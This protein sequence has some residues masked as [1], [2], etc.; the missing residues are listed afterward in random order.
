MKKRVS[1]LIILLILVLL[2]FMPI[3]SNANEET[4]ESRKNINL[5]ENEL[6]LEEGIK[7][8]FENSEEV[9]QYGDFE[10][11]IVIDYEKSD[12]PQC[13]VI[14]K[15]IGTKS[16]V[17][18]PE[19]IEGIPVKTIGTYAFKLC[20][21]LISVNLPNTIEIIGHYA[22][23]QCRNLTNINIS[24]YVRIIGVGAFS[25]CKSLTSINLP[26]TIEV[27]ERYAFYYCH[28]LTNINFPNSVRRIG[29]EAFSYCRSLSEVILPKGAIIGAMAFNRAYVKVIY[30]YR[31]TGA[32][33]YAERYEIEFRYLDEQISDS[34]TSAT[35]SF[36]YDRGFIYSDNYFRKSAT[37]YN[38][39]LATMSLCLAF[40]AYNSEYGRFKDEN[41]EE[42]LKK[43]KFDDERYQSWHYE[44]NKEVDNIACAMS[45]KEIDGET[46]IVIAIRGGGYNNEWGSNFTVGETGDHKGFTD[47]ANKVYNRLDEYILNNNIKGKIKIW[48]TGFSRAAAT[49]NLLAAKLD[50][51]CINS[52]VSYDKNDIYAYC[53]ATPAGADTL[54][55]NPHSKTYNN[56]FNI[57]DYNDPVPLVAPKYWN[58]DRYGITYIF[59]FQE[60]KSKATIY[61]KNMIKRL[62]KLN[63]PGEEEYEYKLKE[64]K[65]R[66]DFANKDSLGTYLRKVVKSLNML[67]FSSRKGYINGT[68]EYRLRDM[69]AKF[70][71]EFNA[72][73]IFEYLKSLLY[74]DQGYLWI[75]MH[76]NLFETFHMNIDLLA[77]VH[78]EQEYYLA[79][80]QSMDSYY[81]SGAKTYMSTGTER[82]VKINCPVD[83]YVYDSSNNLVGSIVDEIPQENDEEYSI[84][85]SIDENDQ[86]V[87]YLPADEEYKIKTVAR[88]DC[89]TTI[90]IEE[91]TGVS[92]TVERIINYEEI[93]MEKDEEIITVANKYE[94]DGF[95]E[96][97]DNIEDS[98]EEPEEPIKNTGEYILQKSGEEVTPDLEISG[99]EI[100]NYSY[101]VMV[102]CDEEKGKVEG[103]GIFNI[104]EYC[105][106]VANSNESYSFDG[107]YVNNEKI[108]SDEIYRFAVKNDVKVQARFNKIQQNNSSFKSSLTSTKET[109]NLGEEFEVSF[110]ISNFEN[111]EK[112]LIA[113]GGQIEY[114]ENLLEIVDINETDSNWNKHTINDENFKFV[115]DSEEFITEDGIVFKI[116]FR[117]K[118]SVSELAQTSIF[119]KNVVAS[120]GI[121]DI[122]SNDAE[123]NINI[124]NTSGFNT[125]LSSNKENVNPKEEFEVSFG[126][127]NLLN[128][129]NGLIALGG[130]L[131]FNK[132]L[133]EI[134]DITETDSKWNKSTINNESFKFVTDSEEFVTEEGIIFKIKFRVKDDV[135]EP[136]QTSIHIKNIEASNGKE[137]ILS[138]DIETCINI[139]ISEEAFI[140]SNEYIIEDD[141]ISRIG[142]KTTLRDFLLNIE[143]NQNIK[144]IDKNGNVL[145]ENDI[146]GTGMT[147]QVGNQ[148]EYQLIVVGDIDGNGE[149]T[150]TDLAKLKLHCIAKEFIVENNEIKAADMDENNEITI[151]DIAQMKLIL[152]GWKEN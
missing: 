104:G 136:T 121:E 63:E 151:T 82:V 36:L 90:T 17:T 108:S 115:T 58:F 2:A 130:Q 56:I 21:S 114:D 76:P 132:E 34:F 148:K 30:G 101:T 28:S 18:I 71:K 27:I 13:I 55:Q 69:W 38:Q 41:V 117:V 51:T 91:C 109:V 50:R 15:Y 120:N 57:I 49:A 29:I 150:I 126:I 83:V 146:I 23:G 95:I 73:N 35:K 103:G 33:S 118:E 94:N 74:V 26:N 19:R 122:P 9:K 106:L 60:S 86:K 124:K 43:C 24:N 39:H 111:I 138:E 46:L 145:Q 123:I 113:L 54:N 16:E 100:D 11:R 92:S 45:N 66:F 89:K 137:D 10:Y 107:W 77:I 80:M 6:T 112:G 79:W 143:T 98:E 116:K 142:A 131:E 42:V 125:Y 3:D 37:I 53:F 70:D 31:G 84:I 97:I 25:E 81:V 134:I 110:N 64:F 152:I 119:I 12:N 144:I 47:A 4:I 1:L 7:E 44:S 67:S 141:F 72:K 59:P 139:E 128:I 65:N 48:V 93:E 129:E 40:S 105:K 127:S 52:A 140:T 133:I 62:K 14:T 96:D 87:L 5:N 147:I 8:R 85:T 75:A 149:I 32:E 99:E 68:F 102:E 61:E 135:S 88:E 78:S 22:F 20:E